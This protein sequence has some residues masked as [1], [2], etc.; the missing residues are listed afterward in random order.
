MR[1]PDPFSSNLKVVRLH[2][3][4]CGSV[5]AWMDAPSDRLTHSSSNLKVSE[6]ACA[7]G[8]DAWVWMPHATARP[9]SSNLK[10]SEAACG[11]GSV[12]WMDAIMT[13]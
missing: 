4:G 10:V 11:C 9:F 2:V 6:A 8:V 7:D 5:D 12:G 1:L 13:A 3:C